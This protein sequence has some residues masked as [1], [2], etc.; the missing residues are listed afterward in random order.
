MRLP[1]FVK[2]KFGALFHLLSNKWCD[3]K[4]CEAVCPDDEAVDGRRAAHLLSDPEVG[5]K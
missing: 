3:E 2:L 5:K 4:R 1:V